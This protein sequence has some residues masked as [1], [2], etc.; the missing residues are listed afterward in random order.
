MEKDVVG[1]RTCWGVHQRTDMIA[2]AMPV[3]CS[4][5]IAVTRTPAERMVTVLHVALNW[6]KP[7]CCQESQASLDKTC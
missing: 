5:Q 3:S 7:M 6:R 2:E 4:V 1:I